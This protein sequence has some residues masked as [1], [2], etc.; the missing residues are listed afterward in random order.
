MPREVQA[1]VI[2]EVSEPSAE[3]VATIVMSGKVLKPEDVDNLAAAA[4]E[5]ASRAAW[6][7][8]DS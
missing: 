3:A 7:G 5:S 1:K 4:A 6:L 2:V 8:S